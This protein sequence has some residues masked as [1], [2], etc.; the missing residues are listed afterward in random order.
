MKRKGRFDGI[1]GNRKGKIGKLFWRQ[2]QQ[3]LIT[4]W[5][6]VYERGGNK[7]GLRGFE[8][9]S[10]ENKSEMAML[11]KRAALRGKTVWVKACWISHHDRMCKWKCSPQIWKGKTRVTF[12]L[13]FSPSFLPSPPPSPS[14]SFFV[15]S[16]WFWVHLRLFFWR[17]LGIHLALSLGF[18]GGSDGKAPAC[19]A[20]DLGSIP[21]SGRSPGE[22]ND[23]A[24][25]YSCLENPMDG[26]A[27]WATAHGVAKSRTRLSDFTLHTLSKLWKS[28]SPL[29]LST[30]SSS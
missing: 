30:L 27:W 12:F 5:T 14:S 16:P 13:F 28:L 1:H 8:L 29:S 23:N 10:Y 26:G 15:H 22:G 4:D 18:P 9:G 25:Q 21:G 7:K 20:G 19:N 17:L 3:D 2:K 6:W 11:I 24:L